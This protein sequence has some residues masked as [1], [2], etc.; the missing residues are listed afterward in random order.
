MRAVLIGVLL[1]LIVS[2]FAYILSDRETPESASRKDSDSRPSANP[3]LKSQPIRPPERQ[4][5]VYWGTL[6]R[7]ISNHLVP[8]TSTLSNIHPADYAGPEACKDCH[9]KNYRDW[10]N[11]PHRWMNA[12]A[13]DGTVVG[14]FSG[15]TRMS[16]KE[17]VATF[18]R[19][20]GEY[21]MRYQRDDLTRTYRI[22]Q[23]IGSRFFQY[24][25][26]KGLEG[27]EPSGHDY[28]RHDHVLPFGYWI[29]RKA[30]VPIVHVHTELPDGQRWDPVFSLTKPVRTNSLHP[31]APGQARGVSS[32]SDDQLSLRYA[33]ACN[34]CHTT[35]PLADMFVR[36]PRTYGQRL[37][38]RTYFSLNNYLTLAHPELWDG[39]R[40]ADSISDKEFVHIHHKMFRYEAK[41]KAV[42]LGISCEACHLGCTEHA[43]GK[44]ERPSFAPNSPCLSVAKDDLPVEQGRSREN[45]NWICSRCHNGNRPTYAAGMATWNS[46]E[47]TD[48]MRGACYSQLTCVH[49]HNPHQATGLQ[50]P[51][52][53]V[54]DDASCLSCH[55][56]YEDLAVRKDH[57]HH[58]AGSAGDRCMNCHMP[59]I[60][61]GMQDVVRT[62]AIFSPT[63][64]DMIEA[65]HPNA[66]NLCHLEKPID[67]TLGYL[68]SWYGRQYS[69]Q[70][71]GANYPNREGAVALGWLKHRFEAVRLVAADALARRGEGGPLLA[72]LAALDDDYLLVRQFAQKGLEDRLGVKLDEEYGYW[73][74]LTKTERQEPIRRIRKSLGPAQANRPPVHP[75]PTKG[76]V[77]GAPH[78]P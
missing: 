38:A 9:K 28:Y 15:D 55:K 27:P 17:G 67:W 71:L 22:T 2:S 4:L 24:Y 25:I 57:T 30:W 16:Y 21:R 31:S 49:C 66:C 41:E 7:T 32:Y 64:K 75:G 3:G 61:E 51:R 65:N 78:R 47:F 54:Q 77:N 69:A 33:A 40:D 19:E 46:T 53:S 36:L 8:S 63:Q 76:Q 68:E 26:G 45:L 29:Q 37:P 50:W 72:M 5:T 56:K 14:D 10:S 11:H 43:A 39:S 34:Y 62:H 59:K 60:N 58:P 52:T 6:P 70:K 44:Q 13:N 74:Y 73:F 23:T 12:L 35:F 18:Y 1:L 42:T 48:A 20:N